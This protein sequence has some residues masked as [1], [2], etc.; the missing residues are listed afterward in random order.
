METFSALLAI[1]AENPLNSPHKSQWC[2]ALMLFLL[3]FAWINGWLNNGEAGDLR[4]HRPIM[5][6]LLCISEFRRF[7][8]SGF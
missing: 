6:S 5:T 1:F 2:G 4:R 8:V 7:V 3:V